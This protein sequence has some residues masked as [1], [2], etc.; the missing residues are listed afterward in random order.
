MLQFAADK[1][2]ELFKS[3]NRLNDKAESNM[4][5]L[6]AF[7]KADELIESINEAAYMFAT[8]WHECACTFAPM[9]E[10]GKGKG[11]AYGVTSSNGHIFYGRGYVQITWDYNYKKL[12]K[13]IGVDLYNNPELALHYDIAYKIMTLG[14]HNGLFTGVGLCK[15]IKPGKYPNYKSARRIINGLDCAESIAAKASKA[16]IY[17]EKSTNG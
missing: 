4:R 12:G 6:L 8:V 15:Y 5:I 1:F 3:E 7:M 16:Q 10:F 2:V 14:V 9:E 17:F 11:R 13:A